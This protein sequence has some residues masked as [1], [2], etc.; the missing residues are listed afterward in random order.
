MLCRRGQA[1][2][3]NAF[4]DFNLFISGGSIANIE[5]VW[6]SRNMKFYPL[7]LKDAVMNEEKLKGAKTFKVR[8]PGK[9]EPHLIGGEPFALVELQ[10]CSVWQ[11][12]NLDVDD[13]C[14]FA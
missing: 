13:A 11:L 14:R 10:N 12:L 2:E 9:P 6:S 8:V 1:L 4:Y 7:S 3:C 5:A